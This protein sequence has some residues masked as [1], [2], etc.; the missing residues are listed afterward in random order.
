M[1]KSSSLVKSQPD[2]PLRIPDHFVPGIGIDPSTSGS[3]A[4]IGLTYYF[5]PV[6]NCTAATCQLSVGFIS[7]TN[8][9]TNWSAPLRSPDR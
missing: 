1:S 9:G 2:S 7:S 3:S 8:G 6:S 5:Y 4:R